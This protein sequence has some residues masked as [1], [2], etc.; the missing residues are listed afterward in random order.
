MGFNCASSLHF[1]L[2]SYC[3]TYLYKTERYSRDF[4]LRSLLANKSGF[5]SVSD[6]NARLR[7]LIAS[8]Q[9]ENRKEAT[10][11]A[12]RDKRQLD[13]RERF[14]QA[15]RDREQ[16]KRDVEQRWS[17]REEIDFYRVRVEIITRDDVIGKSDKI[18]K[19]YLIVIA[20]VYIARRLLVR[21]FFFFFC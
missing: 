8:Y 16:K 21:C 17:R 1:R 12:Q 5:P 11:K 6:L 18:Y 7:R 10:R 13:K 4:S 2:L 14:E 15:V 9:R 19:T 3:P 20:V